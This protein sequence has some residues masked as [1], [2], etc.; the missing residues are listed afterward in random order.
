MLGTTLIVSATS[1]GA[2]KVTL[3]E[4]RGSVTVRGRESVFLSPGQLVIVMPGGK[5]SAA[6]D[7]Q[8]GRQIAGAKLLRG[9]HRPLQSAPLVAASIRSQDRKIQEGKLGPRDPSRPPPS[10]AEGPDAARPP[11]IPLPP[12]PRINTQPGAITADIAIQ[13][14]EASKPKPPPPPRQPPPAA[15]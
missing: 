13:A 1:A 6:I 8:L 7:F 2:M 4:G 10:R 15:K 12:P 9:F 5:L 11:R 3:L 14:R